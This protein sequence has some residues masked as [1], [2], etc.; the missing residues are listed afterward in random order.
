MTPLSQG[1]S[2]AW[3]PGAWIPG[4]C[5]QWCPLP[6]TEELHT[7]LKAP[8][9]EKSITG[10]GSGALHASHMSNQGS[11]QRA[12]A[13]PQRGCLER[14]SEFQGHLGFPGVP[15]S[16]AYAHGCPG[17]TEAHVPLGHVP[18]WT[19]RLPWVSTPECRLMQQ[20]F[21]SSDSP[22][23]P[24]TH[25]LSL[26]AHPLKGFVVK[27]QMVHL[28]YTHMCTGAQVPALNAFQP[29]LWL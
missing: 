14:A 24:G 9:K 27:S 29:T 18:T 15:K 3:V 13:G 8:G 7:P 5:S 1:H 2:Q 12:E 23:R 26:C 25:F 11:T 22:V 4:P 28:W 10:M 17:N 21:L 6:S 20:L 19:T 16:M